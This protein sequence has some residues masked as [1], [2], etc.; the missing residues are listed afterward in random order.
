MIYVEMVTGGRIWKLR[1]SVFLSLLT[2]KDLLEKRRKKE[3]IKIIIF[4]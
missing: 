4:I 2:E 1:F 3:A